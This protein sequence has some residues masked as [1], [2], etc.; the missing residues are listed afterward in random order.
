MYCIYRTTNIV[1]GK[2]YIGQHRYTDLHDDYLGSGVYIKKAI[3]KYG[4][5]N[6]VK[7]I[8]YSRIQY[9]ETADSIEKFAIEKERALGKAEYNIANGGTNG[10]KYTKR[11]EEQ[12]KRISIAHIGMH[13]SEESKRKC[14]IAGKK[15]KGIKRK[16]LSEEHKQ[17]IAEANKERFVTEETRRKLSE[18][19]TGKRHSEET[20][21]KISEAKK[22]KPS[23]NKGKHLSEEA[24]R[25]TSES[26]KRYWENKRKEGR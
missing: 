18:A 24:K 8:L 9:R 12:R 11:N 13:H 14:S 7:E 25:K 21:R 20:K 17:R 1:N 22:G 23:P 10:M 2:T 26:L 16:P 15:G 4:K 6:F 3:K 5:E 19:N